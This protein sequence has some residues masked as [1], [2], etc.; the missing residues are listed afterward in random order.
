MNNKFDYYGWKIFKITATLFVASIF[1]GI[2][3][4]LFTTLFSMITSGAILDVIAVVSYITGFIG[5]IVLSTA[6]MDSL[7]K[8]YKAIVDKIVFEISDSN[9]Y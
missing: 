9:S 6:I 8:I 4:F 7:S 2:S 3:F 5:G 1:G